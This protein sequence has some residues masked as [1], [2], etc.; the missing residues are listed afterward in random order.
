MTDYVKYPG[1]AGNITPGSGNGAARSGG[2]TSWGVRE[3]GV[4]EGGKRWRGCGASWRERPSRRALSPPATSSRPRSGRPPAGRRH[5]SSSPSLP[6][7]STG[8]AST[9]SWRTSSG[10][11]VGSRVSFSLLWCVPGMMPALD[12]FP[13]NSGWS[14]FEAKRRKR[15]PRAASRRGS[16]GTGMAHFRAPSSRCRPFSSWMKRGSWRAGSRAGAAGRSYG[17]GSSASRRADRPREGREAHGHAEAEE[18]RFD[19]LRPGGAGGGL[20]PPGGLVPY[21]RAAR[22][23][24]A[25][26]GLSAGATW[27]PPTRR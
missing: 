7:S 27:S 16:T 19:P 15:A 12:P 6:W 9:S 13:R 3:R 8:T 14:S 23:P 24:E 26:T 21:L 4:R 17:K 10:E 18:A 11:T 5:A 1:P 25:G 2:K 22:P 20:E